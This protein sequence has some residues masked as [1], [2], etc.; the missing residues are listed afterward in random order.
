MNYRTNSISQLTDDRNGK[1]QMK[2]VEECVKEIFAINDRYYDKGVNR[3]DRKWLA[4]PRVTCTHKRFE[5]DSFNFIIRVRFYEAGHGIIVSSTESVQD[6]YNKALIASQRFEKRY[7]LRE[8]I[9][10]LTAELRG[11]LAALV[12]LTGEQPCLSLVKA[13]R[14]VR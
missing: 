14:R 8:E 1:M 6:A 2:S 11:S 7:L 12:A 13:F 3:W 9:K 5:D 10:R 4:S